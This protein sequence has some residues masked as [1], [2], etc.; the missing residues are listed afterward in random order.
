VDRLIADGAPNEHPASAIIGVATDRGRSVEARG[1]AVL[2][3]T[4]SPGVPMMP[5]MFLD[6][7]SV[8]KVASTTA[9][10]MRLVAARQID[11]DDL[12]RSFLPSFAGG[13]KDAVSIRQLLT[14]T[15][16]LRQWWP[17]YMETTDRDEAIERVQQ[18]PL[19]AQPGSTWSYSDL[20]FMLA[21]AIVEAVTDQKLSDAYRQLVAEPLGL[22]STYGPILADTAATAADSDAYEHR[23]VSSGIPYDVPFIS[24]MFAGW[25]DRPLRGE[26]NDGN[27]AHAL[28]GVSGHAGLFSTVD[29]LLTLGLA[30][31]AG[32]FIPWSVVHAFAVPTTVHPEQAV[33]FRRCR[34]DVNGQRITILRHGGFTGTSF[35]FALEQR[36]VFAGAAM[37]LYGTVGALPKHAEAAQQ[38]AIVSLDRIQN[39][40]L[41]AGVDALRA[42][43]ETTDH[44][45]AS[46]KEV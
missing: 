7:A 1:W 44:I 32:D 35:G 43:R 29:D 15:A 36:L 8:T 26:A 6:A 4:G 45:T 3:S 16:G 28:G 23:M 10:M 39:V 9:I 40:V 34:V 38:P 41:E 12:V 22:T 20:G 27:L 11:L 37:R 2:R 31:N 25:R 30:L 18:L 13:G 5:G 14:H 42:D 24:E 21:G 33:G 17:L 19:M 46:S